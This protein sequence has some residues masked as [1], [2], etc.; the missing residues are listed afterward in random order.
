[1][2]GAKKYVG[3]VLLALVLGAWVRASVIMLW[4]FNPLVVHSL[5]VNDPDNDNVIVAGST[6]TYTVRFQKNMAIR[7]RIYRRLVNSSVIWMPVT[8][9]VYGVNRLGEGALTAEILIPS[10]APTGKYALLVT[11]EY[12]IGSYPTRVVTVEAK[13]QEFQ[14][15][16]RTMELQKK[17]LEKE[18]CPPQRR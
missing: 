5:T 18:D 13:S 10:Y 7:P 9:S 3:Y 15:V 6:L 11:Y 16:N 4:P 14:V 12:D 2:N 8:T 17:L 1:M